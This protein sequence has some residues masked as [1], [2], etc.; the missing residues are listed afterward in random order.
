MDKV[1]D[2]VLRRYAA[3]KYFDNELPHSTRSQP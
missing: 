1:S 3:Y 2:E